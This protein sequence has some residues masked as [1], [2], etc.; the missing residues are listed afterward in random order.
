MES[1]AAANSRPTAQ[2]SAPIAFSGRRTINSAP[3]PA[4]N[5]SAIAEAPAVSDSGSSAPG[6]AW[7]WPHASVSA[8][9]DADSASVSPNTHHPRHDLVRIVPSVCHDRREIVTSGVG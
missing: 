6:G 3:S 4:P 5:G 7:M 9:P 2:N 1:D 8:K